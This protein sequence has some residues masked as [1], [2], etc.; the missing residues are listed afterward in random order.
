MTPG[1]GQ[2]CPRGNNLNKHVRGLPEDATH[3]VSKI[4]ATTVF[5]GIWIFEQPKDHL[6]KVHGLGGDVV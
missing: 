1:R 2:F 4:M 3:Q 5:N 6:C